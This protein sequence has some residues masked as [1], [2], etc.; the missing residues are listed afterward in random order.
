MDVIEKGLKFWKNWSFVDCYY[1][2]ISCMKIYWNYVGIFYGWVCYFYF[3]KV[4][5]L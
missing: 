1:E 5:C 3:K 4:M 2:I